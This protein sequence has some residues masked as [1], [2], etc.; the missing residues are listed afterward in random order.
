MCIWGSYI[1]SHG[2]KPNVTIPH[3]IKRLRAIR[4]TPN[5]SY[6]TNLPPKR[7]ACSYVFVKRVVA[8]VGKEQKFLKL[9][10]G[11]FSVVVT[12]KY[13]VVV[14][15]QSLSQSITFYSC[16]RIE[17]SARVVVTEQN[18]CN[19]CITKLPVVVTEQDLWSKSTEIHVVDT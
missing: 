6:V 10:Q 18:S 12:K 17:I 9:P 8:L 1:R 5:T 15:D 14:W 11:T 19:C 4:P 13:P 7:Q 16:H 3:M 2:S